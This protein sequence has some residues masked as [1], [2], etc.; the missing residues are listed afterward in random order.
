MTLSSRRI[1]FLALLI[2]GLII[3]SLWTLTNGLLILSIPL[4]IY[5]STVVIFRPRSLDLV[6]LRQVSK[7]F[8]KPGTD[9]DVRISITNHGYNLDEIRICDTVPNGIR[10]TKGSPVI[11]TTLG[12][13][14]SFTYEYTVSGD[15]GSYEF[16]DISIQATDH[17]GVFIS[18]Q[19]F[20]AAQNLTILP[21]FIRIRS[22]PIR[23]I[24]T[25]GHAG[26]IPSR[27]AGSGTAFFGVREYQPGDPR[28]WLN[29]RLSARNPDQLFSN[30]FEQER[31]ADVGLILDARRRTN[32]TTEHGSIFDFSVQ[33]SAS[34]ADMFLRDGNRV[35]LLIYGRGLERSYP[36][37][38]KYQREKIM[39]ALAYARIGESM[40]FDSFDYLPTR[41]FPAQSQI[42]IVSPLCSADPKILSR[43]KS[44]GY[45]ILVVS[46]DP[47]SYEKTMMYDSEELE[48]GSR[49]ARAQRVL[50]IRYLQRVGIP[51]VDWQ[52]HQPL[53]VALQSTVRRLRRGYL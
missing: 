48:I 50:W 21:T 18:R 42:V 51:V 36:G 13:N 35:A 27:Q 23:P 9:V 31:I 22:V 43:I 47:V 20:S 7:D 41:F 40:V 10:L 24:R 17:F 37:Y 46:P 1:L 32:V 8:V 28:Q 49:I 12:Q 14:A 11:V 15:R 33:A 4:V 25:R 45:N 34:L 39:R 2:Y 52:T 53:D 5:L 6:I 26:S 19:W 30:E 29:W 3:G 38:G 16:H 44:R